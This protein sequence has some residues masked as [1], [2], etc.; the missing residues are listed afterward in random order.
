MRFIVIDDNA[1]ELTT[2]TNAIKDT[3]TTYTNTI[4]I[5]ASS[6]PLDIDIALYDVLFLDI[7]MPEIDGL[8][9]AKKIATLSNPPLIIFITHRADKVYD[10]FSVRP[11]EFIKKDEFNNKIKSVIKRLITYIT[12]EKKEIYFKTT[13]G[14]IALTISKI[15]YCESQDHACNIYT[16]DTSYKSWTKLSEIENKI[17]CIHFINIS[18]SILVNMEHILKIDGAKITLQNDKEIYSSRRN[19]KQVKDQFEKYLIGKI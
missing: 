9:F 11:F 19:I 6:N 8:T 17:N 10:V 4:A 3:I 13:V 12:K 2:I 1:E 15:M 16:K 7:D 14:D 18:K 5:D